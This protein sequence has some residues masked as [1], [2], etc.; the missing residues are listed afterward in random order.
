MRSTATEKECAKRI[1]GEACKISD[2][3]LT[4]A[5]A[6]VNIADN[7]ATTSMFTA[8]KALGSVTDA[9]VSKRKMNI[10]EAA[11]AAKLKPSPIFGGKPLD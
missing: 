11:A 3:E 2:G 6:K 9:Y 10:A 4:I 8:F 5:P 7:K 1:S